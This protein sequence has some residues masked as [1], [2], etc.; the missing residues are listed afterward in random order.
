MHPSW[1]SDWGG[2]LKFK[3]CDVEQIEPTPNRFVW[4]NP[5]VLH[6]IEVVNHNSSH[7][8]VTFVSWP[9]GCVEYSGATLQINTHI[10]E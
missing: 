1:Q 10:Q 3:D 6:G 2:H 7:N 4:I 8:R 9:E 5:V